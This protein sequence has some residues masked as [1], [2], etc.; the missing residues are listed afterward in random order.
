MV[1]SLRFGHDVFFGPPP[2]D[3]PRQPLR[4]GA[5][6]AR[7]RGTAGAGLRGRRHCPAWT[8]GPVLALAAQPVVGGT[9]PAYS[10]AVW[11]GFNTPLVM[12]LIA[13]AGGVLVY[14]RFADR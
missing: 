12:G 4:A 6:D 14:L 1:Y 8:I 9:L 5:L 10:L 11:H 2:T 7:S 3:C 13:T